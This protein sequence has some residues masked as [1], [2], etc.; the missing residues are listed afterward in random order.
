[1]TRDL[2]LLI[3]SITCKKCAGEGEL[4]SRAT[5]VT[6]GRYAVK[7]DRYVCTE[8]DGRGIQPMDGAGAQA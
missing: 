8:C 6:F 5:T 1:M 7:V 4:A 2:E 3:A